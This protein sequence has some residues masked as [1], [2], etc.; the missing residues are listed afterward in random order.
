[1]KRPDLWKLVWELSGIIG[2][3]PGPLTL[4][5]ILWMAYGR[6]HEEWNRA[7]LLCAL[8]ANIHRDPKKCPA[9]K[10]TDFHPHERNARKTGIPITAGNIRILKEVFVDR[11]PPG[12]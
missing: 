5:E 8:M 3:N 7:S 1:V 9:F 10:P 11:P 4:R 2:V 12:R 6:S